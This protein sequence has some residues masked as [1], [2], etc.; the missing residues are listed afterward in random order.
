[1]TDRQTETR[2]ERERPITLFTERTTE[3]NVFHGILILFCFGYKEW[4][5]LIFLRVFVYFY[6]VLKLKVVAIDINMCK[7]N[8]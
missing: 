3:K 5:L 2:K 8:E 4:T 1:M 6:I 7:M